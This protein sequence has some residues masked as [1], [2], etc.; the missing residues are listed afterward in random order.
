MAED[1]P[2][3][4]AITE[5][6]SK[7]RSYKIEYIK[8]RDYITFESNLRCVGRRGVAVLVHSS[9]EHSVSALEANTE[10]QESLWLNFTLQNG[11]NILFGNV[12]HSPISSEEK[13][14]VLNLVMGKMC[15]PAPG[16]FSHICV[17]GDFNLS[18]IRWSATHVP[19]WKSSRLNLLI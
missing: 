12:Y 8:I 18:R 5:V 10:F 14:G 17:V 2:D 13:A 15:S 7:G 9:H 6:N 16:R 11:D 4:V 3:I 1:Q 19:L